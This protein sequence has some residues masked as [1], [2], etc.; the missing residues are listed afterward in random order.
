MNT[1]NTNFKNSGIAWI[2][3]IPKHWEVTKINHLYSQRN[4]KVSDKDFEPLSV[5]KKG[6]LPQLENAAKTDNG[7]NRK[8]VKIGDFVI[9]SRLDR[10][11]SCGISKFNG[12]VSLINIVLEPRQNMN[13]KYF[14][15]LFHTTLFADEFYKYGNGIVDD[16]WS[17][18]W[19]NMKNILVPYP[20]LNEQERIAEFLDKKCAS[21]D[22]SIENLEQK[23]KSLAEYKKALITQCVTKGL[24]PKILEFKDSGIPWIGQIPKHWEISKIKYIAKLKT[25]G[26]PNNS[27][28]IN[29][30]NNGY[31]WITPANIDENFNIKADKFITEKSLKISNFSLFYSNTILLIG[32]GATVGK[33]GY[34]L[35]KSYCNQQI[36]A[37]VPFNINSKFLLYY[38]HFIKHKIILEASTNTLPIINN[39]ILN[40]ISVIYPPLAEQEKIAGFLDKKCEK[41]DNLSANYKE[42]IKT[43]KEYKKA[44]IYECVTGKK[45]I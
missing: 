32:I 23:I 36:T 27:F 6:I 8:L 45:E 17:T 9:N 37:L 28:G 41:I 14:D 18:R 10:R 25:G 20:P 16:L 22:S 19:G 33:I 44:L 13:S 5:T 12:S 31:P 11:G 29:V 43:L 38:L 30:E 24:N 40:N 26:T 7:D 39:K 15:W 4:Q 42:Q 2:G 1:K 21:I 3:E 34:L 35:E